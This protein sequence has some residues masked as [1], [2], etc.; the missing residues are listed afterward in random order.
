MEA[1]KDA[2]K[3]INP[4]LN[5]ENLD[6]EARENALNV[7]AQLD[8]SKIYY[9]W[10]EQLSESLESGEIFKYFPIPEHENE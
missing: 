8:H 9:E 5:K 2:E 7:K 6:E 10:L 1:I 4:L 3:I